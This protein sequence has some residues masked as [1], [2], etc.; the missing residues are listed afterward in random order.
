M[1]K[2]GE[3]LSCPICHK[4]VVVIEITPEE[5]NWYKRKFSCNDRSRLW[6]PESLVET[7]GIIAE[8]KSRTIDHRY[9]QTHRVDKNANSKIIPC[10]RCGHS[11]TEHKFLKGY[12]GSH[13]CYLCKCPDYTS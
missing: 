12:T 2:L 7:I 3:F 9:G 8:V 13:N 5:N 1:S 10:K 4:H 11:G 6:S